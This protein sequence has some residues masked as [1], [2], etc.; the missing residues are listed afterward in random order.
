MQIIAFVTDT[1]SIRRILAHLGEPDEPSSLSPARGPP[2]HQG[3]PWD[4]DPATALRQP[5]CRRRST[6]RGG[7]PDFDPNVDPQP[8]LDTDQSLAW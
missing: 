5:R 7:R 4:F 3:E 8:E 6:P 2:E 1:A